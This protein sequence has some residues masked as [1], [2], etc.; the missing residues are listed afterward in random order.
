MRTGRI[1]A[2]VVGC[3]LALPAGAMFLA[4][5][6]LGAAYLFGR[7]DGY[8]TATIDR[9][10]TDTVAV[11]ADD[12]SLGTDPGSPDRLIDALDVDVRLDVVPTSAD[13]SV[14]VG[15]GPQRDVDAFL[16]GVAHERIV[17]LSNGLVPEY[18]AIPGADEAPPPAD[19]SFWVAQSSGTGR[20]VVEWEA[21]EGDW[22]IVLMNADGSPGVAAE[23]EAGA[24]SDIVAPLALGLL[25]VGAVLM[26]VA[27]GL[28]VIGA[29]GAA[30]PAAPAVAMPEGAPVAPFGGPVTHHVD[31]VA[32][33]ARLDPDLSRWQWLVKWFLAIPHFIVLAFLW[34]AFAVLT[35]IAAV[36]I[37]FTGR[38]PRGI[39]Q[40]NV[41]VL[42]WT[43]RVSYY[44]TTGGIGTDRYPPFRLAAEPDDPARLDVDYPERLSRPLVLVKWLLAIPHLVIVAVLAGGS[45]RWLA[46]DGDRVWFDPSGGGGLLGLL[47][48]VAGVAL[49]FTGRYPAALFDLIVGLNRWVY[50]VIAYVALMTDR[51]PPFRLDQGGDEPVPPP[52]A[53]PPPMT[54]A[55]APLPPPAAPAPVAGDGTAVR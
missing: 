43:W 49:L 21:D 52:D 26:A 11:T 25:G 32:L 9:V 3:L 47:V 10:A 35:L 40:F 41:G 1:V 28:I 42:R 17:D 23:V 39:F 2:L 45:V 54:G 48:L 37:L 19:Q 5:G 34:V 53:T 46:T 13:T 31:P 24:K 30:T 51:Y 8:F 4:G 29:K 44:A 20:Q 22:A 12:L 16:S 33:R 27:V 15:I 38:Y 36:A 7:D 18:E 14:F 50:R 6:A 55:A